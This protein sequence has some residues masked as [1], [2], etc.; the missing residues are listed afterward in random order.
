MSEPSFEQFGGVLAAP[1]RRPWRLMIAAVTAVAVAVALIAMGVVMV[2]AKPAVPRTRSPIATIKDPPGGKGTRA[3]AF[4]PDGTILAIEDQN[5]RTYFWDLAARRWAGSLPPGRCRGGA[6]EV[7]FSPDGKTLA[8]IGGQ[9]SD[10][11]PGGISCLWDLASGREVATF[12]VPLGLLDP[13]RDPDGA[14]GG[15]AGAAF[16]PNGKTLAIADS[17]GDTYLWDVAT[18]RQ[19]AV[20][21]APHVTDPNETIF[22]NAIAFSPDGKALA[23]ADDLET[24]I[25]DLATHR[26]AATLTDPGG[27]SEPGGSGE[28]KAV[29]FSR[30]GTLAIGDGNGNVY[31]W[32]VASRR[33]TATLAQPVDPPLCN[34]EFN[35]PNEDGYGLVEPDGSPLN[36][37]VAFSPDGRVLATKVDCGRGLYLWNVARSRTP[38]TLTAPGIDVFPSPIAFSP[39][40]AMVA[41]F[42]G[43]TGMWRVG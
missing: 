35:Q 24:T 42:N 34:G 14:T 13:K 16:S 1:P 12:V 4:S 18:G 27:G 28:A 39:D 6:A 38:V 41:N 20:F 3:G 31:L 21:T 19:V 17:N 37:S 23:V 2:T 32:D 10:G 7:L 36:A 26:V 15:A 11:S 8:V 30:D 29:A 33:V 5:G 43:V 40:S 22:V 25:W 9:R